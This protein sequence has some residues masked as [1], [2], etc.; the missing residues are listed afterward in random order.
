MSV[1]DCALFGLRLAFVGAGERV[2]TVQEIVERTEA[3][4]LQKMETA[5]LDDLER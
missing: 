2:L 4:I 1:L 3:S 5:I